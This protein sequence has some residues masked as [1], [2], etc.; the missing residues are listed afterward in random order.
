MTH[1]RH[2]AGEASFTDYILECAI[3]DRT[4]FLEAMAHCT[5]EGSKQ[6]IEETNLEIVH[7]KARLKRRRKGRKSCSR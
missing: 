6:T 4:A 7:I 3:N 5:D 2:F 1:P